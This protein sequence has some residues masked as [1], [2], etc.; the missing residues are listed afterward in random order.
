MT[1]E[2]CCRVYSKA[3]TIERLVGAVDAHGQIDQTTLANWATYSRA[4]CAVVSKGGKEFWKVQQTNAD[5]SHVWWCAYSKALA[6]A[7][8]DMRLIC[9][10][11]RYDILSIVDI[12]LAHREIEIQTRRAVQ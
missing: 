5:V 3:V 9:E 7:T 12:D 2:T 8:P 6:D 1:S 4:Y 11:V 10:G